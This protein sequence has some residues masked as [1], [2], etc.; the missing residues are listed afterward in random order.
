MK[1]STTTARPVGVATSTSLTATGTASSGFTPR[2]C[3]R[4][5]AM[6]LA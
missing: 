3:S 5:C 2:I 4:S 1:P 6:P